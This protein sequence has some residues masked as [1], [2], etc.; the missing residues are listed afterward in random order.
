VSA[1]RK[2]AQRALE[3]ARGV[4]PTSRGLNEARLLLGQVRPILLGYPGVISVGVGLRQE[5]GKLKSE[6]AFVVG[7]ER[8]HTPRRKSEMLPAKL[9]GIPVDVQEIAMP[10]TRLSV[11]AGG[12]VRRAGFQ[13]TGHIGLM[14]CDATGSTYVITAYHVL[15]REQFGTALHFGDPLSFDVEV[16]NSDGGFAPAGKLAAAEFDVDSDIA[17][18]KLNGGVGSPFLR[19]TN[20]RPGEPM[21]PNVLRL[22]CPIRMVVPTHGV[23]TG[24]LIQSP[25]DR[26]SVLTESGRASFGNLLQFRLDVSSVPHGWSGSLIHLPRTRAPLA[27]LSFAVDGDGPGGSSLAYGFPLN[28]HYRTWGLAPL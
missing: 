18:I 20:V 14:A 4:R 21:D 5:K 10:T 28:A 6:I 19:G 26:L 12:N 1:R 11:A 2:S 22:P 15:G 8:K 9:L 13:E 16:T 24:E 17:C 7:V 27:L 25:I 3:H 23:V